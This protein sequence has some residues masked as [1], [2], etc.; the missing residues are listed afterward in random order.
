MGI[1]PQNYCGFYNSI[2]LHQWFIADSVADLKCE[3]SKSALFLSTWKIRHVNIS[4]NMFT[5]SSAKLSYKLMFFFF[6]YFFYAIYFLCG[7]FYTFPQKGLIVYETF[8]FR[9]WTQTVF[10]GLSALEQQFR[11]TPCPRLLDANTITVLLSEQHWSVCG[12]YF[13]AMFSYWS[14]SGTHFR[15]KF[16]LTAHKSRIGVKSALSA[17]HRH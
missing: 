3:Q 14:P 17:L 6:I 16:I 9:Q 7:F 2:N 15:C 8:T 11:Q 1:L 13:I 4:L 5:Y 12:D 10:T